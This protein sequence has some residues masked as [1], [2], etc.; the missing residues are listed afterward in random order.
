MVKDAKKLNVTLHLDSGLQKKVFECLK[1]DDI[2][3]SQLIVSLL[4][5]Y[6][7]SVWNVD[8]DYIEDISMDNSDEL[9]FY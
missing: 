9:L 3:I 5:D 7:E 4:E 2:N 6:V 1:D 8:A